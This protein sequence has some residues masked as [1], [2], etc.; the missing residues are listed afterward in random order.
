MTKKPPPS[1]HKST[2]NYVKTHCESCAAGWTRTVE[3][4]GQTRK[5]V[6]CLLDRQVPFQGLMDCDRYQPK[7]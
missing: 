4:Q 3:D 6:V 7:L 2:S 5:Y 1:S